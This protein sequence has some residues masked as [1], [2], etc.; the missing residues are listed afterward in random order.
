MS[1]MGVI[2]SGKWYAVC[3]RSYVR[4]TGMNMLIVIIIVALLAYAGFA[5]YRTHVTVQRKR[6]EEEDGEWPGPRRLR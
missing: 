4:E 6:R 3:I 2:H 5:A 1:G